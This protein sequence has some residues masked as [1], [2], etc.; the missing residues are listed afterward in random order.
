MSTTTFE[1][2]HGSQEEPAPGLTEWIRTLVPQREQRYFGILD[3]S[4]GRRM[5]EY[6]GSETA[7]SLTATLF[8]Q[9]FLV[10]R[11]PNFTNGLKAL[12]PAADWPDFIIVPDGRGQFS[13]V[14]FGGDEPQDR[15]YSTSIFPQPASSDYFQAWRRQVRHRLRR[16]YARLPFRTADRL[17]AFEQIVED[18][19]YSF[20]NQVQEAL[21]PSVVFAQ[22]IEWENTHCTCPPDSQEVCLEIDGRGIA[23]VGVYAENRDGIQGA[24]IPYHAVKEQVRQRIYDP[25]LVPV[26]VRNEPFEILSI[27]PIS[28]SCF[29]APADRGN[30]NNFDPTYG[31]LV[32]IIP[33]SEEDVFFEGAVS[34][35]KDAYITGWTPDL[36]VV[37]ED[38]QLRVFTNAVTSPGDSG[39]A[40]RNKDGYV[41]GF[42]FRRSALRRKVQMSSWI[43]ADSVFQAHGL[44]Y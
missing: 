42:A 13:L 2:E 41:L 36:P 27:D 16:Q 35:K 37:A 9:V 8:W 6:F 34:G 23:T 44:I 22:R 5:A 3:N 30:V 24:T 29:I 14:G 17:S 4:T 10:T 19:D 21:Q 33:R 28:D 7:E 15:V 39:A 25:S 31:P 12:K 20:F 38:C 32:G 40:L 26:Y 43:W 1:F 11:F 18:L